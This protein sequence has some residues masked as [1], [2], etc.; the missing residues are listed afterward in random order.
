MAPR[1]HIL[2]V[3]ALDGHFAPAFE[4]Y[5]RLLRRFVTLEVREV[6]TVPL[7]G[8]GEAEVLRDEGRRLLAVR[9]ALGHTV[10]LDSA[11]RM[12]DSLAFADELQRR[13]DEGPVTF[14]IGGPLGLDGAVRSAVD[15]LLSL[16]SLTLPHQLARVVLAEQLFRGLKI[17]RGETYH[18]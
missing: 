14:V 6:K 13:L 17:A 3:G 12:L 5:R 10:A 4:H 18:H 15:E 2:A 8:R 7:R 1:I 16:S 9:P 11:G